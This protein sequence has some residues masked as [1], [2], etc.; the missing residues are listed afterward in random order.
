MLQLR[1]LCQGR[2][3]RRHV[4]AHG[5]SDIGAVASG[6]PSK[7]RPAG[8]CVRAMSLGRRDLPRPRR[9]KR[10]RA[11]VDCAV[12]KRPE[13]VR[14]AAVLTVLHLGARESTPGPLSGSGARTRRCHTDSGWIARPA[15]RPRQTR[16]PVVTRIQ[17]PLVMNLNPAVGL[18]YGGSRLNNKAHLRSEM[19]LAT[20]RSQVDQTAR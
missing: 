9:I 16:S 5:M 17:E 18:S 4:D 13:I 3:I 20:P 8:P 12:P 7:W 15:R 10:L 14:H 11:R 1:R 19:G 2:S 6:L